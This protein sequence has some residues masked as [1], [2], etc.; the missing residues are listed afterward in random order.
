[1]PLPKPVC[2][3]LVERIGKENALIKQKA[4]IGE[5]E[6]VYEQTQSLR[7]HEE[8]LTEVVRLLTDKTFGVIQNTN[9]IQVVGHRVVHGG[10]AY[11]SATLIDDE[12]KE[13]IKALFFLAPLHN[14]ANYTG[15]EVAEKIFA[16]AKQIA[17]FDTAFHQTLSPLAFRYAIPETFYKEDKIRVYGFHGTSHKYVTEQAAKYLQNQTAKLISIHLGNGCSM[18]AVKDG[19]CIDTSM[20]FSPLAGLIMGTRTGDIDA[21]VVFYLLSKGYSF[22]EIDTVFNKQ[23]GMLALAGYNDMRDVN[24]AAAEGNAAA[25]LALEMY[26]YRIQK[27]IGAYIAILNGVDAIIFTA[28]VGENDAAMRQR[29]CT[30]LSFFHIEI[31]A[32]TN[33]ERSQFIREISPSNARV[34]LLVVPTNEELEI[35]NQCFELIHSK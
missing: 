16:K 34:K 22:S 8:G 12:V 30:N 28:G 32:K 3:G 2:A 31:D 21:S 11:S 23:S 19:K 17:V 10:E 14:P 9:E 6:K 18:A 13:T 4:F 35:A 20:G 26:A 33:E 24:N 27:Y 7:N 29:I 5:E 1:M 25:K 15:I